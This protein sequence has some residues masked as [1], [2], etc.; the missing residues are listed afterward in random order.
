MAKIQ[1][2][3]GKTV[4]FDG[5]PTPQDID[6]VAQQMKIAPNKPKMDYRGGALS[7]ANVQAKSDLNNKR[8]NTELVDVPVSI[9]NFASNATWPLSRIGAKT[10]TPDPTTSGGKLLSDMGAFANPL[11]GEAIGLAGKGMGK[12][13]NVAAKIPIGGGFNVGDMANKAARPIEDKIYNLYNYAIGSKLKNVGDVTKLKTDRVNAM[14]AISDNLPNIKLQNPETGELEKRIP[15]NRLDLLH[16]FKQSKNLIWDKVSQMS[17]GAT[18]KQALIDLPSIAGK[19]VEDAKKTIGRVAL[20]SNPGLSQG[21]DNALHNIKVVGRV[22]PK[23][24]EEYMKWLFSETQRLKNSGQAV[25]YSVKDLYSN[26]LGKLNEQTD[27]TIE[28][29]LEQGGYKDLRSQYASLKSAEKEI[30]GAAN[31]HLRTEGKGGSSHPFV[32]L[33]SLEDVLQGAGD[34]ATGDMRTGASKIARGTIIKGASKLSDYMRNPDRRIPQ[35]FELIGKNKTAPTFK[36]ADNLGKSDVGKVGELYAEPEIA[37]KPLSM[38]AA[39][40][41]GTGANID[42]NK[43]HKIE[44]GNNP[45]AVSNKGA[46]GVDQVTK[47]ALADWNKTHPREKYEMGNMT[48]ADTNKKVAKWY[49]NSRIPQMLKAYKIPDTKENRLRAYNEGVGNLKKGKNPKETQDYVRKYNR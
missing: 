42:M 25:D 45:K 14:K 22:T 28:K 12:L 9:G 11:T 31:K 15:Q 44:S 3:N 41:V 33:W 10:P 27:A 18:D 1:F 4:E 47:P 34:M 2:E 26:L 17:Q 36:V 40:A 16:S 43:I 7:P 23:E 24:S 35:M 5:N 30:I 21:L 48:D 49:M 37:K 8:L 6:H 19:A 20:A 29:T 46:V 39:G 38:A 32:D 13:G